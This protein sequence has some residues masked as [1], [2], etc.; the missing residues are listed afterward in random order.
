ME[1]VSTYIQN[2]TYLIRIPNAKKVIIGNL[3]I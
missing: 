3:G 1:A 2:F